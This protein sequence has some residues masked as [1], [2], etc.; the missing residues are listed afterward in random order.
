MINPCIPRLDPLWPVHTSQVSH[1]LL[2]VGHIEII[3]VHMHW[4]GSLLP[5]V[6]TVRVPG[7]SE[8]LNQIDEEFPSRNTQVLTNFMI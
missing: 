2:R 4:D 5:E 8:L 1:N 7:N 3:D 6:K